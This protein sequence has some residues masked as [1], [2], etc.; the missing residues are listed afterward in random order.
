LIEYANT[1]YLY[2]EKTV[3]VINPRID[4]YWQDS[5]TNKWLNH[6][7]FTVNPGDHLLVF[8][9]GIPSGSGW[10]LSSDLSSDSALPAGSDNQ[11]HLS[12]HVGLLGNPSGENMTANYNM[13]FEHRASIFYFDRENKRI[14]TALSTQ[15]VAPPY[16]CVFD[17][18]VQTNT[19][20]D[21]VLM[22]DIVIDDLAMDK[23]YER[24]S[25]FIM[26]WSAGNAPDINIIEAF[27][28]SLW[29]QWAINDNYKT[30]EYLL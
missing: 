23:F 4:D 8:M 27:M 17:G 18:I 20:H 6:G 16:N 28:E 21:D 13:G 14:R 29:E 12:A 5:Y 26:K 9:S 7:S 10:K 15:D 22:G 11:L 1:V 2:S 30:H 25:V 19:T 24:G 3:S